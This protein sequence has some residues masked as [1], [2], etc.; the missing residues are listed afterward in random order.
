MEGPIH[1]AHQQSG[2]VAIA[3]EIEPRVTKPLESDGQ[4]H[5]RLI[6]LIECV[7]RFNEEESPVLLLVM[8][9]PQEAHC[10]DAPLN[11]CLRPSANLVHTTRVLCL[12]SWDLQDILFHQLM[13]SPKKGE[14]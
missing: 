12:L 6:L 9:L 5:F 10:M 3:V 8:I 2:L 4:N 11:T 7:L 14:A 13:Y 1:V